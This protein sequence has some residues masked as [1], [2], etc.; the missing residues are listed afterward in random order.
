MKDPAAQQATAIRLAEV[1]HELDDLE[2]S[3][4]LLLERIERLREKVLKSG[5]R[6]TSTR[7]AVDLLS[8]HITDVAFAEMMKL[9]TH[10]RDLGI[11][12]DSIL[13]DFDSLHF[14]SESLDHSISDVE[15]EVE[16]VSRQMLDGKSKYPRGH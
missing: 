2:A 8:E 1:S 3:R 12:F 7:A 4:L 14:E 11:G 10:L 16:R 5:N 15:D 9:E 6:A 13:Q